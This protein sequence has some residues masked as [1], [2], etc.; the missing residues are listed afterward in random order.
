MKD[1]NFYENLALSI[2]N[3]YI[4][5]NPPE[6]QAWDWNE[7][8]L[9]FSFMELYKITKKNVLINYVKKWMDQNICLSYKVNRNEFWPCALS[10]ISLCKVYPSS[11]YFGVADDVIKYLTTNAPRTKDGGICSFDLK[12]CKTRSLWVDALFMFGMVFARWSEFTLDKNILDE[13][14]KQIRIFSKKLQQDSGLFLH[15]W[16]WVHNNLEA[17]KLSY[18][19]KSLESFPTVQNLQQESNVFWGRGNSW[20]IV[21]IHEYLRIKKKWNERDKLV[22]K[23]LKKQVKAILSYQD[24][25]TGLWWTV[26]N[27]PGKTY[28]ET[29]ASAF[30][31][32]GLAIGY[33]MGIGNKYSK[34][35]ITKAVNGLM[36][37]I[38]KE[39]NNRITVIGTSDATAMGNFEHYANIKVRNN[40]PY[41]IGSV[42][43]LLS[44]VSKFKEYK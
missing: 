2:C 27:R 36:S 24:S 16:G 23:I 19:K 26:L 43:L 17:Q 33:N 44:E 28:L 35:A 31:A 38:V 22:E 32:Y 37:R 40:T 18:D 11:Q 21:S 15:T 3:Q 20:S 7:A 30:F 4:K 42:I 9:M 10:A 39:P 25:K 13:F 12:Y 6:T 8:I 34:Q 41:G 14:G 5:N 1:D 29:S